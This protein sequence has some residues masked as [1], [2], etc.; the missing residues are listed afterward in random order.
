TPDVVGTYRLRLTV[1][2]GARGETDVRVAI[3]RD[4]EGLRIPA[5][6]EGEEANYP[7]GDGTLNDQGYW[8]DLSRLLETSRIQEYHY[9]YDVVLQLE[10]LGSSDGVE[11][12]NK[13]RLRSG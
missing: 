8:P 7:I 3:V 1:N 13:A 6:G 12:G 9:R 2:N 4:S 11:V 10:A 5:A